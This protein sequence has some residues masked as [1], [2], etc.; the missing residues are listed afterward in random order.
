MQ[1]YSMVRQCEMTIKSKIISSRLVCSDRFWI[2]SV[3]QLFRFVFNQQELNAEL[4]AAQSEIGSQQQLYIVN[5]CSEI[6]KETLVCIA[7]WN[8]STA[9][10]N[11]STFQRFDEF[12]I[13]ERSAEHV[14]C[15]S[16]IATK[17][18]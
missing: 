1:N 10:I 7:S 11:G 8:R 3:I 13:D 17:S 9:A 16:T 18:Q 5:F 2:H 6:R 12:I 15:W 4:L 14:K